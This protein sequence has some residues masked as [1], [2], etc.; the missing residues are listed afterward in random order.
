MAKRFRA[1]IISLGSLSSRWTF[2]AMKKYFSHVDSFN[3]KNIEIDLGSKQPRIICDDQPMVQYDCIYS[4]GSFRYAD[5]LGAIKTTMEDTTYMPVTSMAFRIGHDKVLSHIAMQN[6]KVP[7]PITYLSS[8]VKAAKNILKKINYPIIMKLPSGTQGKGVMFAESYESASSFLDT[9]EALKQ[10]FLIQ[11]YV[12]TDGQDIR[13]IV[14][15]DKVVAAMKR[16]AKSDEKRA[17]V[18]AGGSAE[19]VV[20]DT[21]TRN[22][23]VEAARAIGAEI[24]GVDILETIKGPVVIEVNLSPGLQGITKATKVDVADKI[25]KYLF[26]RTSEQCDQGRTEDTSKLM[27][28]LGISQAGEEPK[29]IITNLD[30]RGDKILLPEL[31]THVT[32]FTES[33]EVVFKVSE[34]KLVIEKFDV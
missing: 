30:F 23:A 12:E 27:D 16:I 15:G 34:G 8:S 28:N 32:K 17:N 22:I 2:E 3:I 6:H 25:A 31:I 1:A 18:H 29:E 10:P 9:L 11:E 13:A 7:M 20:L 5:V 26:K 14:V 33:K 19:P 4:K 21:H 24:C